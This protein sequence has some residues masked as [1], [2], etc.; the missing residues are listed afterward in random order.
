[1]ARL[2]VAVWP[3]AAVLDLIEEL[4]RPEAEGVRWTRRD[5]WHITL[6]FFGE[7]DPEIASAA[8]ATVAADA[9]VADLGPASEVLG[10]GV[11]VVPVRG[12]EAIAAA[13]VE[14]TA[15][16]GRPPEDRPFLGHLT[17]ARRW[18]KPRRG[19]AAL[20]ALAGVEVAARWPVTELTLVQSRLS[21][22]G[23]RYEAVGSVPLG[24][25]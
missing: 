11:L 16:V 17:L 13:V 15:T 24:M 6:R 18:G 5:Q 22:E 20:R 25:R 10:S 7:A 1:M 9:A 8:L 2:F 23:A 12:I 3:P 21:R 14:A 19:T 4:P